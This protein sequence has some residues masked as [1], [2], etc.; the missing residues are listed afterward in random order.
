MWVAPK[1]LARAAQPPGLVGVESGA[2]LMMGPRM[3]GI[4]YEAFFM[5]HLAPDVVGLTLDGPF[6][7]IPSPK[8]FSFKCNAAVW[9]K[10]FVLLFF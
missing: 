2:G 8:K 4:R 1:L 3:M 7:H 9:N 5:K 6:K 10:I